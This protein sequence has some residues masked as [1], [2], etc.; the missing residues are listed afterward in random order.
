MSNPGPSNQQS[1][2]SA[3]ITGT[4]DAKGAITSILSPDG[5]NLA[6]PSGLQSLNTLNG[7][8]PITNPSGL[9]PWRRGLDDAHFSCAKIIWPG[10]STTFGTWSDNISAATTDL[11]A[12][13]NS[14]AG[15]LRFLF[16]QYLGGNVAGFMGVQQDVVT[17][18][19]TSIASS[20]QAPNGMVGIISNTGTCTFPLPAC[21]TIEILTFEDNGADG[22][23]VTGNYSYQIDGG[24]IV[25]IVTSGL[26]NNWRSVQITGLANT[27]HSVVITGTSANTPRLVGINYY[28][29]AAIGAYGG[30]GV[31]VGRFGRPG[32]ALAD[33][34]GTGFNNPLSTNAPAKLGLLRALSLNNP[35]L[36]ILQYGI[37]DFRNQSNPA[38]GS[39]IVSYEANIRACCN[40]VISSGGCCLLLADNASN[41]PILP[42]GP[43]SQADFNA[44]MQKV[45]LDTPFVAY[46]NIADLFG[47]WAQ[48]N[49]AGLMADVNHPFRLGYG[50]IARSVFKLLTSNLLAEGS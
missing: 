11:V 28:G 39:D 32:W 41:S 44:V 30:G 26:A 43:F 16:A 7:A 27:A 29:A 48:A 25:P 6:I 24:T 50:G 36:L 31:S 12:D 8:L 33:L 45:A 1:V 5:K 20:V 3:C 40:Q 18:V 13:I 14:A 23:S 9:R 42:A 47:T 19:N 37:N 4:V 15:Q 46:A 22:A 10:D 2:N 34:L 38:W 17:R 35:H 49:A 21:T